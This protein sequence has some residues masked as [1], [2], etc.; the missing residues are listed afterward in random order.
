MKLLLKNASQVLQVVSDGRRFLRGEEE[1]KELALI[2][3][4]SVVI[5]G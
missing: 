4:A 5:N 3:N 2:E 1:L